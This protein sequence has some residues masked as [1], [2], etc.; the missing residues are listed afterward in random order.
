EHSIDGGVFNAS[1]AMTAVIEA[2]IAIRESR[3]DLETLPEESFEEISLFHNRNNYARGNTQSCELW[4]REDRSASAEPPEDILLL[5]VGCGTK[6]REALSLPNKTTSW[7]YLQWLIP[8]PLNHFSSLLTLMMNAQEEITNDNLRHARELF[9]SLYYHR[10]QIPL[11]LGVLPY[12]ALS[13]IVLLKPYVMQQLEAATTS[14]AA[15]N[16][17]RAAMNWIHESGWLNSGV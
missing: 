1:P 13:L 4:S 12:N 17:V 15:Q 8:S 6:M 10:L 16:K 5:S 11:K 14:Q 3:A 9:P 2:A 7:G